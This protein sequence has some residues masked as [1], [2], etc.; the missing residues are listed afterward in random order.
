MDLC[1]FGDNLFGKLPLRS[2]NENNKKGNENNKKGNE[3]NKKRNENYKK[4]ML[5]EWA[6]ESLEWFG[7][8]GCKSCWGY[9]KSLFQ[10]PDI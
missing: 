8:G 5:G 2:G 1:F 9:E 3:N 4:G 10:M 6:S 7:S